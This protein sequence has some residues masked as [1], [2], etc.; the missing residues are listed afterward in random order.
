MKYGYEARVRVEASAARAVSSALHCKI[1]MISCSGYEDC[2]A[3]IIP[4]GFE[5][6][7]SRPLAGTAKDDTL[8]H[9]YA[10]GIISYS[11][12]LRSKELEV[13]YAVCYRY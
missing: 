3:I 13:F 7:R 9:R 8:Y 11:L 10:Y 5:S 12:S 6:I 4:T 1:H 2:C